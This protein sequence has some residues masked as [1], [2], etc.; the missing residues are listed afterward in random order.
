M[1]TYR[2]IKKKSSHL[3]W[4]L[5]ISTFLIAAVLLFSHQAN[6]LAKGIQ[7]PSKKDCMLD[8]NEPGPHYNICSYP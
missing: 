6:S 1:H 4:R 7:I 5:I 2:D 8:P 3:T